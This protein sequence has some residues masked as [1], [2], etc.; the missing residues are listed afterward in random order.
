MEESLRADIR[1]TL[2]RKL[3]TMG[4]WG[5]GHVCESNLKKGFP[6]HLKGFVLEVADELRKEG[7]MVM[8]PSSHDRQWHLNF[9]KKNEIEKIIG[10]AGIIA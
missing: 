1:K 7:F 2:M 3:Y 6:P 10:A 4:C 8:R 5:K 9:D